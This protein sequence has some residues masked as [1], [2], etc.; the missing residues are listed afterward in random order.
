LAINTKPLAFAYLLP[1]CVY[2]SIQLLKRVRFSQLILAGVAC[3]LIL[4]FINA[5]YM[6]RNLT[7]YSHPLG[8]SSGI[9]MH[10]NEIL[11]WRVLISNTLRNASLHAWSPIRVVRSA[12]YLAILEI[13][14]FM[15]IGIA[16]PRTS[17][18]DTFAIRTPSTDEKKAG[19]FYHGILILGVL[20]ILGIGSKKD[21][22]QIWIY[23][24]TVLFTFVV[25][26][27]AYKFS[28]FGS[29][30]HLTFFVLSA[31]FVG[32]VL[33]KY[34]SNIFLTLLGCFLF[35]SSWNWLVGIDQRPIWPKEEVG[36]S[37]LE[38]TRQDLYFP[39][40]L[41][42]RERY[43]E[44][45]TLIQAN[46]CNQIGIMLRGGNAEY[47]IWVYL[48]APAEDLRIEWI[49]EGTPSASY[50]FEN[51]KPCAVI[52]DTSCPKEWDMVKDLPLFENKEGYRLYMR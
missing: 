7:L 27:T 24:L 16:D 22:K 41:P 10:S 29:R 4:G 12:T 26:S 43:Q 3:I 34:T 18:H 49:V 39:Q 44:L 36:M 9:S 21:N 52:C 13:H 23:T 33:E 14:E 19:N 32:Y 47:P 50:K 17:V 40:D 45:T 2:I 30:Y 35:I 15:D 5:G 31:P 25:L 38:S 51:F 28:I 37:L 11:D 1:F 42:I 48:G 6:V 46:R 8:P 20:V